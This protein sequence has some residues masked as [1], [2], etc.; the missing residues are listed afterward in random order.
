MNKEIERKFLVDK[1]ILQQIKNGSNIIQ[2]YIPTINGI[3]ARVRIMSNEAFLTLKG[4]RC[5]ITRSE[6]EYKISIDEAKEMISSLCY[7]FFIHKTRYKLG[8]SD[9]NWEIDIFHDDND[10]LIIAEV[11]L[12]NETEVIK[13]P[14]WVT[15][16]ITEDERYYNSNLLKNPYKNW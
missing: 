16:E 14:E 1:T 7:K 8:Y 2:A 6:F 10:G 15:Q 12:T 13:Y 5:G 4:K 9:Q 3:T 11:E